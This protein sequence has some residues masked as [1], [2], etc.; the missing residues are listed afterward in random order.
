MIS[1]YYFIHE[2]LRFGFKIILESD[3]INHAKSLLNIIPNFPDIGID[4]RFFNKILKGM[5]TIHARLISQYVF[6]YHI[7]FSA[8]FFR[9]NEEDQGSD[10]TELF[11]NLSNNKNL[12]ETDIHNID[13]KSQLEH[14]LQI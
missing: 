1:P 6:K 5:A 8:S 9:V 13:V 3:K 11:I 10:E 2:N 4:I 7:I 12:T 14:Q